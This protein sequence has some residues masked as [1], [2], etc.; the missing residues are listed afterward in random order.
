M[1]RFD[2]CALAAIASALNREM[3][4]ADY[5]PMLAH[6][7]ES[8]SVIDKQISANVAVLIEDVYCLQHCRVMT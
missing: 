1:T 6:E 3:I 4:N 8:L 5:V 7:K 2:R